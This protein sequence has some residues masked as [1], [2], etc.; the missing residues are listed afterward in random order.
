MQTQRRGRG[1]TQR[2]RQD[3]DIREHD[4]GAQRAGRPLNAAA[5]GGS[6]VCR[7]PPPSV[8]EVWFKAAGI[9][10]GFEWKQLR[11]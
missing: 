1:Q 6:A 11:L 9:K 7:E 8:D 3:A 4:N 5:V 2:S 10:P